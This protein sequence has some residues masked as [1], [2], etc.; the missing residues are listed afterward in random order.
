M[1][2]AS[3]G[4]LA[5]VIP[6]PAQIGFYPAALA[7]AAALRRCW[8]TL[9]FA[10]LPLGRARDVPAT[11]LFREMGVEAAGWP[12]KALCRAGAAAACAGAARLA[13][14]VLQR[15]AHRHRSS[16]A[17]PIFAFIVLRA[18]GVCRAMAGAPQPARALGRRCGWRSATSTGPAR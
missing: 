7:L 14:L 11:A 12:R 18:V 2:F 17:P 6:I 16:S 4:S 15:P 5:S 3:A 10:L 13:D 8:S 1:P 9:A